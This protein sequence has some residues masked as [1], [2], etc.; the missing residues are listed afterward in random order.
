LSNKKWTALLIEEIENSIWDQHSNKYLV[1]VDKKQN[2]ISKYRMAY[3]GR[4]GTFTCCDEDENGNII[5]YEEEDDE[6]NL[7]MRDSCGRC[8]LYLGESGCIDKDLKIKLD[9]EITPQAFIDK[10]GTIIKIN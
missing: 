4:F 2:L 8:P 1:T 10:R 9:G 5:Q 7:T 3:Y 6:G